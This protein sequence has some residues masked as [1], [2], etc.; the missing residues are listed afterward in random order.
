MSST[1]LKIAA[2][3][4]VL[5]AIVLAVVAFQMTRSYTASE[6]QQQATGG[7]DEASGAQTASAD[8]EQAVIAVEPLRA[9]QPISEEQVRVAPVAVLPEGHFESV[10]DVIDR[11]PLVDVDAGAPL[12]GRYFKQA[13]ELARI[14]PDDHKAVS[15]EVDDVIAV[16]GFL[17]PGDIVDVLI[18]LRGGADV[19]D[20]QARRLLDEVRVLALD[21]RIIDRPEGVE[22]DED[23]E[24]RRRQRTVVLAVPDDKV[25]RLMLGSNLGSI[26]LA[27][28]GQA[29]EIAQLDALSDAARAERESAGTDMNGAGDGTEVA[30]AADAGAQEP[31][32]DDA[33]KDAGKK[34]DDSET[35]DDP[36]TAEQLSRI[37]AKQQARP[38]HRIYV[39]S[40]SDVQTVLD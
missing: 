40:G 4:T 21:D 37:K 20:V 39:Y 12:T 9:L 26:R 13:N 14:I 28:H 3:V 38:R 32:Q 17:Q 8:M 30:E 31:K 10:D 1:A 22:D 2:V 35:D 6:P 16:G 27:M 34:A 11:I 29:P 36:L 18:Y 24:R 15:L 5:L 25:T 33:G 19:D 7:G 23:A